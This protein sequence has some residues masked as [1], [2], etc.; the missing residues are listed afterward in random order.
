M[1]VHYSIGPAAALFTLLIVG[2]LISCFSR[3][4]RRKGFGGFDRSP[5]LT[6]SPELPHQPLHRNLLF[7]FRRSYR[8]HHCRIGRHSF[9]R[10][11]SPAL[12]EG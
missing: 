11:R 3:G 12:R 4:P 5:D 10:F 6:V 8:L 1:T 9:R 2:S 7:A